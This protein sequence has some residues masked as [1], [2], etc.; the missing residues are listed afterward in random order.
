M[1]NVYDRALELANNMDNLFEQVKL[2]ADQNNI[3][4]HKS[5]QHTDTVLL[6]CLKYN[7]DNIFKPE[8]EKTIRNH[9][10]ERVQKYRK[11]LEVCNGHQKKHANWKKCQTG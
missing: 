11:N 3:T 7:Y 1:K 10:T 2:S 8:P 6:K 5:R 9:N 4:F